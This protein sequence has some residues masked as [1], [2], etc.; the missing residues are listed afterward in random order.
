M[1][2]DVTELM[3]HRSNAIRFDY[4]FD[5]RHTDVECVELPSDVNILDDGIRITGEAVDT[6]GCICVHRMRTHIGHMC[7][8]TVDKHSTWNRYFQP[9]CP[10]VDTSCHTILSVVASAT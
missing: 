9:P 7:I 4:T 10:K 6:L 2:I 1:K 5:P 3:N 8:H